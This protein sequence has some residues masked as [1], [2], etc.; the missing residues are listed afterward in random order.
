LSPA[1]QPLLH[2]EIVTVHGRH[3]MVELTGG[4]L[5]KCFPRGKR[6]LA[7]C[8]DRVAVVRTGADQG[9][10]EAID[11]RR[12]L[13]YRSDPFKQKLIAANVTQ[14]VIVLATVPS[15]YE[16]LLNRCLAAAAQQD[17]AALIVLNKIDLAPAHPEALEKLELY[18]GLGYAVQP[19]TAKQDVNPL[20]Q[21]LRGH[22]SVLVGQSGMGKSTIVNGLVPDAKARVGDVSIAL[23]SGRHTTTHS[24]LYRL[25]A[26]TALIDSPGLQEFGIA[27]LTLRE[28][29]EAYLEFRPFLGH[30]RFSDCRH[31][32]EPG[33]AI[34][35]AKQAGAITEG[36][37]EIYRRLARELQAGKDRYT[38]MR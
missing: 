18:R 25:D 2:G 33:C 8:A 4:E 21:H 26:D 7:A 5:L 37:L 22:C 12:S 3:Y 10:I 23:D 27:H 11:P 38:R 16:E 19:L 15:F 32:G 9:V 30:C 34:D 31:C 29:A 14:M 35:A 24:Q 13:L 17:I 1:P 28:L 36:R 6:S 20:R